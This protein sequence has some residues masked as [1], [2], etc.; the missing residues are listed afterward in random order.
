MNSFYR[1]CKSLYGFVRKPDLY[2][3]IINTSRY[4]ESADF[5]LWLKTW[6]CWTKDPEENEASTTNW[7]RLCDHGPVGQRAPLCSGPRR[8]TKGLRGP[9]TQLTVTSLFKAPERLM[10]NTQQGHKHI[11]IDH[12]IKLSSNLITGPGLQLQSAKPRPSSSPRPL[13]PAPPPRWWVDHKQRSTGNKNIVNKD[14][15]YNNTEANWK[16]CKSHAWIH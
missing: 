5:I 14:V 4:D 11:D 9:D 7:P 6:T 10:N 13:G 15:N 12:N 1:I 16:Q 8:T 3:F 2:E